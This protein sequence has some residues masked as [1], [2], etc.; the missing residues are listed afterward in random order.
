MERYYNKL[1]THYL[2]HPGTMQYPEYVSASINSKYDVV[3]KV[4]DPSK[5]EIIRQVV[6][7]DTISWFD[8]DTSTRGLFSKLPTIKECLVQTGIQ[9]A[10]DLDSR[11]SP[12]WVQDK[13]GYFSMEKH[14]EG[15]VSAWIEQNDWQS[16]Y[17]Y[18]SPYTR[19]EKVAVKSKAQYNMALASEMLGKID[20]AI[21]WADQSYRTE[22]R[23]QTDYYL[24]K[25][26]NR[27]A[28]LNQF[29]KLEE[30]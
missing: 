26:G 19:S 10:L 7:A 20:E 18:W 1:I 24:R 29:K 6:V 15:K 16:A 11:L 27:K 3:V 23:S 28:T 8:T 9:V 22:Y 13:R 30:K 2:I 14:D 21:H 4:Y 25:L 5:K 17:D 12:A